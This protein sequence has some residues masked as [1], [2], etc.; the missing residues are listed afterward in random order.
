M[1]MLSG[2]NAWRLVLTMALLSPVRVV[3]LDEPIG[4]LDPLARHAARRLISLFRDTKTIILCTHSLGIMLKGA[5]YVARA[6]SYL[7]GKFGTESR[8]DVLFT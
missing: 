8:L 7:A 3:L 1:R 5:I 6:P 2:G 4:S